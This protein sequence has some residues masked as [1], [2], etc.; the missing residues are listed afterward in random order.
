MATGT[1]RT[2]DELAAHVATDTTQDSQTEHGAVI[3]VTLRHDGTQEAL[4]KVDDLRS[5]TAQTVNTYR[6][7]RRDSAAWTMAG[8]V[9]VGVAVATAETATQEVTL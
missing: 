8:C 4:R 5:V 6:I 2:F 1:F 7:F 9:T 3:A